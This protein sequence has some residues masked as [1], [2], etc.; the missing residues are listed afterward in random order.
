MLGLWTGLYA[1]SV[2]YLCMYRNPLRIRCFQQDV[3][4][5]HDR[6]LG[7]RAYVLC[8]SYGTFLVQKPNFGSRVPFCLKQRC[9]Y[10]RINSTGLIV[11]IA[12]RVQSVLFAST[13]TDSS[14]INPTAGGLFLRAVRQRW[15][16]LLRAFIW[17]LVRSSDPGSMKTFLR[18]RIQVLRVIIYP[19]MSW[20]PSNRY[21]A[22]SF[23]TVLW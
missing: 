10:I 9:T 14:I 3:F 21:G 11:C 13:A 15:S 6:E 22:R 1:F 8:K 12:P 4:N 23:M 7:P 2:E 5:V 18:S 17:S 20:W 16:T 19:F